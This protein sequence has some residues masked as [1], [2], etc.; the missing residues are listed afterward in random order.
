[1]TLKFVS[2]PAAAVVAT[3]IAA[4]PALAQERREHRSDGARAPQAEQRRSENNNDNRNRGERAQPR[5]EAAPRAQQQ[6]GE[7]QRAEQPRA[8]QPRA[9]QPRAE[10]Q[11]V[12]PQRAEP[13]RGEAVPRVEQR[14]DGRDGAR[15]AVI[16]PRA[17]PR[18][19][20]PIIVAPRVER[21]IIVAP[22]YDNRHYGGDRYYDRGRWSGYRGYDPFRPYYFRP[23]YRLG[24]GVYI[25]Y[26]VQYYAYPYPV[27]VYGYGAP[28]SEV[29]V[30]PNAT[31]GGVALEIRPDD[32]AV[33]VDGAYAGI[34]R[35]FDGTRQPLTLTPGP[36]HIQIDQTGFEPLAFDVTVQPGQVI[37]YQGDLRPY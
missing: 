37:P 32:G 33:Y 29:Y 15:G 1:M 27:P 17:V 5:A 26:P 25:G 8:E 28:Y 30:G 34:V 18:T 6:R 35:D 24:F 36:H 3:V 9:Q 20:R 4:T 10:A 12:E 31:Y 23:R 22:R 2:I 16:A 13:R 11:R 14:R 21:P 7:Q 19:E